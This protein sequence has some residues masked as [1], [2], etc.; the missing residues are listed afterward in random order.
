M[1]KCD[2]CG[3]VFDKP[4]P[5]HELNGDG[6]HTWTEHFWVCPVCGE[7]HMEAVEECPV[8]CGWMPKGCHCCGKCCDNLKDKLGTFIQ[9]LDPAEVDQLDDW[10]DGR[11]IKD[12]GEFA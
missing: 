7:D 1:Y 3:L 9:S 11:S 12:W 10:L 2:I 6:E 5:R 8:C 4:F